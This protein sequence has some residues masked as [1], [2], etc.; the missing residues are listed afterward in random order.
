MQP[1]QKMSYRIPIWVAVGA[2]T[3]CAIAWLCEG[4]Y[5]YWH[6][7]RLVNFLAAWIPFVLSTLIAFVPEREMSTLKKYLWRSGVIG[8]GFAWSV[9]LWHQQVVMDEVTKVDQTRI[10]TQAVTQSNIHSDEQIAGVRKDFQ[11]ESATLD[12]KI[13]GLSG[14]LSSTETHISGSISKIILPDPQYA[15]LQFSFYS[16]M[17]DFPLTTI[18]SSPDK[19]GVFSVDF[20]AKNT[21]DTTATKQADMWL[22]V[23][24]DCSVVEAPGFDQPKGLEEHARHKMVPNLNPGVAYEKMTLRV[25]PKHPF[26]FFDLGFRY[27][28][29]FCGKIKDAQIMKV[30]VVA[31]A[32]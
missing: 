26:P 15:K 25:K 18:S 4:I 8:V 14:Q 30:L 19:D 22:Y 6:D 23:C 29:E 10:V 11:S 12:E 7:V 20:Y 16:T 31:T 24:D 21:S 9:V 32:Q 5:F 17:G 27:A 1:S 2:V 3:L 28:C 13:K